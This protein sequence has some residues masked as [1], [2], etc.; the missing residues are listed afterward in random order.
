ME[1]NYS[2]TIAHPFVIMLKPI[3][4]L[5]TGRVRVGVVKSLMAYMIIPRMVF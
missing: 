5:Q 4:P 2:N 3:C 1:E